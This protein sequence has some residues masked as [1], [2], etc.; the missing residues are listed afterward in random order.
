MA[1]YSPLK[2]RTGIPHLN[3][4]DVRVTHLPGHPACPFP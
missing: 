3:L 1:K 2:I 4:D